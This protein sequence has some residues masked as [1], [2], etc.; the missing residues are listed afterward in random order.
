MY[1]VPCTCNLFIY[2]SQLQI[3]DK[4]HDDISTSKDKVFD[5][6]VSHKDNSCKCIFLFNRGN[7]NSFQVFLKLL[8]LHLRKKENTNTACVEWKQVKGR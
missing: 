1:K 8:S 7:L 5:S 2:V 3:F 4:S 6:Y